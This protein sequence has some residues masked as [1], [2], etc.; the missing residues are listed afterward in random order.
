M[1]RLF[2]AFALFVAACATDAPPAEAVGTIG[3]QGESYPILARGDA[4]YVK[5]DGL[6]VACRAATERDC[7]WALRARLNALD[8]WDD[9]DKP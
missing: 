3:F 1:T 9:L 5:V 6:P 2:P 8:A 7:Y 4:W